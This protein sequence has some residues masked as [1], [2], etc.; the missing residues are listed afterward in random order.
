M[1]YGGSAHSN[2][3]YVT[4]NYSIKEKRLIGFSEYLNIKSEKNKKFILSQLNM[5]LKEKQ[6]VIKKFYP[7]CFNI[8][9]RNI[10]FNFADYE[11]ASYAEGAI[12]VKVSKNDLRRVINK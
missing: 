5:R 12:R 3:G 9:K 11:I 6:I 10:W 7:F 2:D 4:Y 8:E 1:Y